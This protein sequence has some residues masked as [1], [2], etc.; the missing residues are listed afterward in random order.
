MDS[1]NLLVHTMAAYIEKPD[2]FQIKKLAH[3]RD[4][5]AAI[6]GRLPDAKL[7]ELIDN[8][9][10]IQ[11]QSKWQIGSVSEKESVCLANG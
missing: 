9:K 6:Y 8:W 10:A 7:K 11:D 2:F 1:L 3:I 4:A 5:F